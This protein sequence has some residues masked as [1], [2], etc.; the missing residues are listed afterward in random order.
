L[1]A[2]CVRVCVRACVWVVCLWCV[3]ICVR[4]SVV[5]CGVGRCGCVCALS[6]LCVF[7][8][9]MLGLCKRKCEFCVCGCLLCARR[10]SVWRVCV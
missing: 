6:S 3:G 5:L 9:S 8:V 2:V 4:I 7:T 10:Y 1:C